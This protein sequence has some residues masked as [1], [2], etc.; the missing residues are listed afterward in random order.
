MSADTATVIVKVKG[1]WWCG[2]MQN[3]FEGITLDDLSY[4]GFR[5]FD[6]E[7]GALKHAK[8]QDSEYG[9]RFLTINQK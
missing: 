8:T 6:S 2:V 9:I 1:K 4:N 7:V 5:S 3:A